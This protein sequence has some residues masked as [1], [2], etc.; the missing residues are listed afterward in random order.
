MAI[1]TA[2]VVLWVG[3]LIGSYEAEVQELYTEIEELE[4]EI[5]EQK[6]ENLVISQGI[7]RELPPR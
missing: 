6:A 4:A 3:I 5:E 2:G 7:N 1:F